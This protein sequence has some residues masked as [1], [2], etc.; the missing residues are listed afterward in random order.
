M[1][2]QLIAI[3]LLVFFCIANSTRPQFQNDETCA[4]VESET[5]RKVPDYVRKALAL[6]RFSSCLVADRDSIVFHVLSH[7]ENDENEVTKSM[8]TE[9]FIFRMIMIIYLL[10][11]LNLFQS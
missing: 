2:T 8:L 9:T 1:I 5:K 3:V 7:C 10:V 6:I 11:P 4:V